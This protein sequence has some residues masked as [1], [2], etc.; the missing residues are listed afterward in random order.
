MTRESLSKDQNDVMDVIA[1]FLVA[2]AGG[3]VVITRDE[4]DQL[5]GFEATV[6]VNK[7]GNTIRVRLLKE[8]VH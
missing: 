4:W 3:E 6:A 5:V 8:P 7:K 2:K 1:A